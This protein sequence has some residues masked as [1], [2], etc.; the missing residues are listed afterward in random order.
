EL[1]RNAVPRMVPYGDRPL[2]HLRIAT[3]VDLHATLAL[4]ALT[5][6]H[7]EEG[8]SPDSAFDH[9]LTAAEH[10]LSEGDYEPCF[11]MFERTLAQPVPVVTL[12]Q[13]AL[14]Y[15]QAA[16]LQG[17]PDRVAE[18]RARAERAVAAC[19]EYVRRDLEPLLDQLKESPASPALS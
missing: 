9:Y 7:F 10:A 6:E 17:E 13:G 12:A 2:L 15:L 4:G 11:A 5:A 1:L 16:L 18:A 19:P 3:W 14:A 8:G